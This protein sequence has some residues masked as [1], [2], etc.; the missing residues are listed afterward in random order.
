MTNRIKNHVPIMKPIVDPLIKYIHHNKNSIRYQELST[1]LVIGPCRRRYLEW[2]FLH[3]MC[4]TSR[5][6]FVAL[7]CL[8]KDM[9]L[10]QHHHFC[11]FNNA[12]TME[13]YCLFVH[14]NNKVCKLL[15]TYLW[16]SGC[17]YICARLPPAI[18][19]EDRY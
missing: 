10:A 9:K 13:V 8:K 16:A 2:I 3:M 18:L 5:I 4:H 7:K 19:I 17:A 12:V 1:I 6:I 14:N 15:N 11:I